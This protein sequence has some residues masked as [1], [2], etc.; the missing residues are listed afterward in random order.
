[1]VSQIALFVFEKG[2]GEE[3]EIDNDWDIEHQVV[4]G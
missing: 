3:Q 4:P 1:L 2:K